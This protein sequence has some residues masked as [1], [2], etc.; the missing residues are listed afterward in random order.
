R[1]GQL[2]IVVGDY[3]SVTEP[4]ALQR[5]DDLEGASV[6]IFQSGKRSFHPKAW[7][8]RS[9][10]SGGVAVV[11]SSNLSLTALTSGTEWNLHS[12]DAKDPVARAFEALFVHPD[13]LPL[14]AEWIAKYASRRQVSTPGFEEPE[15]AEFLVEGPERETPQPH[16]VQEAALNALRQTR[17]AG[18]NAGM[19][20]M[21]TGLGKTWLAAIDSMHFRRVLFVAHREEI[22]SQSAEAF[23]RF[24][25]LSPFGRYDGKHKDT[26]GDVLFASVS[27]LSRQE[28]LAAFER[29]SFDYIVI[30]EFHHAAAQ[31]YR[32]LIDYFQPHFLLGLTATPERTDREDL[33]ALCNVHL[34]FYCDLFEGIERE[35][36]SPF[37]YFGV[38]DEVDYEQIPWRS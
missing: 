10:D 7:L 21:A 19:V 24:R 2:R 30:D 36:L 38:P 25:P 35:L 29:D 23:R 8:F 31:S 20:V 27:T 37:H 1:G 22:L 3:L 11:G 12:A 26:E 13:T 14:T 17:G 15:L 32:R 6:R 34:V 16:E 28:H 4:E 9:G 33:L 18:Q 5:L